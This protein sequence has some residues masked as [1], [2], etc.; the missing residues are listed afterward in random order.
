[1]LCEKRELSCHLAEV[2]N[3]ASPSKKRRH[4]LTIDDAAKEFEAAAH[5]HEA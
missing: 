5:E 3:N 2:E 4:H 1:M